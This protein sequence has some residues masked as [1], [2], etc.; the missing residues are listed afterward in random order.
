[1]STLKINLDKDDLNELLEGKGIGIAAPRQVRENTDIQF[2]EIQY[3]E[4]LKPCPFCGGEAE[5]RN[6][7][8]Q[9]GNHYYSVIYV[10]C[11]KCGART[12]E[13]ISDGYFDEYCSNEEIAELWNARV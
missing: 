4:A 1:M 8:R 9:D 7:T 5:I 13:K 11:S 10:E 2:I 12:L 6:D 3:A